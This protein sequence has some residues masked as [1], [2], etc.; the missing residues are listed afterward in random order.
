[1]DADALPREMYVTYLE[2]RKIELQKLQKAVAEGRVEDFKVV[3][4]QLK[5]NAP[6]YGFDDLAVIAKKLE[7][8]SAENLKTV[9]VS[10]LEE[11]AGWIQTTEVQLNSKK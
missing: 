10:L 1:M 4:H 5:G 9:G 2:R 11:Y 3:G 6:S 8:V 7:L